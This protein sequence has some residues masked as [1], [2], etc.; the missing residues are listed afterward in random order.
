MRKRIGT[1]I[2]GVVAIV[3]ASLASLVLVAAPAGAVSVNDETSFRDAWANQTAVDL[4]ADITLTC[5]GGGAAVRNSGDAITVDAHRFTITQT[6]AGDEALTQSGVGQ[7]MLVNLTLVGGVVGV[8]SNG[9]VSLLGVTVTGQ[10]DDGPA[11]GVAVQG[12]DVFVT[13]SVIS[14]VTSTTNEAYGVLVVGGD[15]TSTAGT[16]TDVSGPDAAIGLMAQSGS[17][18][19]TRTAISTIGKGVSEDVFGILASDAVTTTNLR[20]SGLS[21]TDVAY[22]IA[23]NGTVTVTESSV[24]DLTTGNFVVGVY[25]SGGALSLVRSTVASLHGDQ[26]AFGVFGP[27]ASLV[28]STV[29][30]VEGVGVYAESATIAYSDIVGNGTDSFD[31]DLTATEVGGLTLASPLVGQVD[32]PASQIYVADLEI[33]ATVVTSPLLGFTNCFDET[34]VTSRGYNFADDLTCA[35]TSTGDAQAVGANPL[36][37]ALADNGGNT[38]TL[39][40]QSGSPLLDAIPAAACQTAPATGVTTDQRSEPRPGFVNCDIGSVELQP[41]VVQPTFTG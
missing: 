20:V 32:P 41:V 2:A 6:C 36:L 34:T 10:S 8:E 18:T 25:G 13:S 26:G 29:T 19:A 12:A 4:T 22:G 16:I 28:N 1:P 3:G 38:P 27:A 7:V 9:D 24:R 21:G 15:I 17:V 39:L 31:V 40:P 11:A 5:G 30:G 14:S 33:F 23:G 35:L 37:G